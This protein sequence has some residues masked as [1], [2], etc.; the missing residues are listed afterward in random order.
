M[1]KTPIKNVDQLKGIKSIGDTIRRKLQE[2]I[3]TGTLAVLEKAK[4]NPIFIFTE[5]YGIGP[6]KA[7]ELVKKHKV[8]TIDELRARQDEILNDVQKKGLRY[9][10]DIL[11]RI[12]RKEI[13][14]YEKELT[15]IFNKV[16]NKDSTFQIMGSYRRGKKDSGDIDICISDPNDDANVF[17][18]FIDALIEKNILIEVL[19]RG[20]TKSLGLVNYVGNLQDEL[21]LCLQNTMNCRLHFYISQEAKNLILL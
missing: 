13:E 6:K 12:P 18:N 21:I 5:V 4:T 9:Y 20:N 17:N 7:Q 15:K 19:S 1:I 16:K 2:Y 3:D 10:E 11:K 14:T 8:K